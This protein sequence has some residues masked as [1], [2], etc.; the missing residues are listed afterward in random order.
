MANQ[1]R[2]GCEGA[3]FEENWREPRRNFRDRAYTAHIGLPGETVRV[4]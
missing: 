3:N 4:V 2:P 1:I